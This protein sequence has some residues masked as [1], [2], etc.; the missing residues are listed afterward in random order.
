MDGVVA[1]QQ[2]LLLLHLWVEVKLQRQVAT[3]ADA[4]A[5]AGTYEAAVCITAALLALLE[6]L[7]RRVSR[8]SD[9]ELHWH[10]MHL[11]VWFAARYVKLEAKRLQGSLHC[12]DALLCV[13]TRWAQVSV[14]DHCDGAGSANPNVIFEV[15][16]AAC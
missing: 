5:S 9:S 8:G 13:A 12:Q 10:L 2:H 14:A 7:R 16:K 11:Q 6:A 15:A 3:V 4:E 1:C